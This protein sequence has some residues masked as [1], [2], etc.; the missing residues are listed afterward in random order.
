MGIELAKA[1]IRIGADQSGLRTSLDNI[2][3]EVS[4]AVR[5]I[6]A[7]AAGVLGSFAMFGKNLLQQSFAAARDA[8]AAMARFRQVFAES[9]D[10]MQVWASAF[11]KSLGK[12]EGAILSALATVQGFGKGLG[13][14]TG[15]ANEFSKKVAQI[16]V[17]LAA[18]ADISD[19]EAFSRLRA[20]LAGSAEVLDQFG[21]NVKMDALEEFLGKSAAKAT[22]AEKFEA[23][24]KAID[25]ALERM[26]AKGQALREMDQVGERFKRLEASARDL[27][28]NLGMA[29]LAPFGKVADVLAQVNRNVSDFVGKFPEM[30]SAALAGSVAFGTLGASIFGAVA[31]SKLLGISLKSALIGSGIGIFILALGAGVG[32]LV[33]WFMKSAQAAQ[34]L[35][36]AVQEISGVWENVKIAA[37]GFFKTVQDYI[38]LHR[39]EF[40]QMGALVVEIFWNL[41]DAGKQVFASIKDFVVETASQAVQAFNWMFGT[42]YKSITE[43]F[44]AAIKQVLNFLDAISILTTDWNLTWEFIKI[45]GNQALLY[46]YDKLLMYL[47]TMKAAVMGFGS[48]WWS[49]MRDTGFQVVEVFKTVTG[50]V[51]G[52]FKGLWEGIKNKFSGGDFI[53]GF[54]EEFNKEMAKIGERMQTIGRNASEAF[55]KTFAANL[56]EDSPLKNEISALQSEADRV[57]KEMEA[58]RDKQRVERK[59]N[60]KKTKEEKPKAATQPKMPSDM[61]KDA[62]L[63]SL[64][65]GRYGFA[66]L[67]QKMQDM[68]LKNDKDDEQKKQTGFLEAGLAKQDEVIKA[69]KEQGSK[70]ATLT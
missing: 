18:F 67:G 53:S 14:S 56:G 19:D 40:E 35:K 42:S 31:A 55:S 49:I 47:D 68:L 54:T 33:N 23:R 59:Q 65:Q 20:A 4:N 57:W 62:G 13:F 17:D 50:V 64:D 38:N 25:K 3:G 27:R 61:A 48:A 7:G 58:A 9:A 28:K 16:A 8:E 1:Y 32:L 36:V 69:I 5:D 12:S 43:F 30:S 26:G 39:A 21:I 15:K 66:E 37:M 63:P 60:E 45:K 44:D 52:L 6:A 46:V 70:P 10:E 11:A 29:L 34:F 24:I 41:Y 22:E 51:E 2:K